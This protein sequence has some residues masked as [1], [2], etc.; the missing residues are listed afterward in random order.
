MLYTVLNVSKGDNMND[1]CD[2]YNCY[3]ELSLALLGGKWK[4]LL[5]H[6]VKELDV[7]RF[8]ELK[9]AIPGITERMLSKQLKELVRDKFLTRVQYNTMPPKVE[10]TLTIQGHEAMVIVEQLKKF[11]QRYNEAFN[12]A[13]VL[14][15]NY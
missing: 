13:T 8:G 9:R 2:Q 10:Y 11:G 1:L 12:V 14:N 3:I 7:A 15:K 6:H 5:L 4:P